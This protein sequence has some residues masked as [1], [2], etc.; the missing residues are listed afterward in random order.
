MARRIFYGELVFPEQKNIPLPTGEPPFTEREMEVL[1]LFCKGMKISEIAAVLCVSDNT[2]RKHI[3]NM[4]IKA[5]FN[6]SMELVVYV[7]S[8]GWIN[9][10]I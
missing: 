2:A 8:N 9:P 6:T 10:N 7:V 3:D 1:R 4:R 5:G